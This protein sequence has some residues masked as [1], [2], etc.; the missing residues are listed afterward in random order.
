MTVHP[1]LKQ[2]YG[3]APDRQLQPGNPAAHER[4]RLP[5]LPSGPDGVHDVP[6]RRTWP[7]TRPARPL[8]PQIGPEGGDSAPL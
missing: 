8:A 2:T 5:L 1:P 3:R 4:D 7:S 6:L